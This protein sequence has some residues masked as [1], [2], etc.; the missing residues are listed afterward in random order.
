MKDCVRKRRDVPAEGHLGGTPT[1]GRREAKQGAE[2]G[3]DE[4]PLQLRRRARS[5]REDQHSAGSDGASGGVHGRSQQR[6]DKKPI[7]VS[8]N[9]SEGSL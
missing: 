4:D 3:I 6:G 9:W 7:L 5:V 1:R 8:N 2:E